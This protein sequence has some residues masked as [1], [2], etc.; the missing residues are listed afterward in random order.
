MNE[1]IIR[2]FEG[3]AVVFTNI[4]STGKDVAKG[5]AIEN[6]PTTISDKARNINLWAVLRQYLRNV[7][8]VPIEVTTTPNDLKKE[9]T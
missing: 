6:S 4:N 7:K 1:I 2:S 5:V 3:K 8:A 9:E